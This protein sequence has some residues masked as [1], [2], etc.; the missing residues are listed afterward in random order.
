MELFEYIDMS[1][2]P[3][4]AY[5]IAV[6]LMMAPVVRIFM[7]AGL[8]PHF[9]LLLLVPM[10]GFVLVAAALAFQKWPAAQPLVLKKR[11]KKS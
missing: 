7:R 5:Y 2:Q 11:E 3:V 6:M 1:R 8:R 9:A 10:M 4:W